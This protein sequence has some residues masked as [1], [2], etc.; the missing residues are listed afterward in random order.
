MCTLFLDS[1]EFCEPCAAACDSESFVD[2]QSARLNPLTSKDLGEDKK[3]EAECIPPTRG[4]GQDK[5]YIWLG[6]G[7][8]F[9]MIF[10]G[11]S[12]YAYPTLFMDSA[13]LAAMQ[14]E[15][16]LEEGSNCSLLGLC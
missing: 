3:R 12:V 10:L 13:T 6:V 1:G 7:A 2:K 16:R 11:L 5:L 8:S 9:S 15:Q 4:R 14:A